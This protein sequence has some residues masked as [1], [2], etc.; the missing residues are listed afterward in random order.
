MIRTKIRRIEKE[1]KKKQLGYNNE[2][3]DVQL[4]EALPP[5]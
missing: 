1:R 3:N 4:L 2:D 5:K